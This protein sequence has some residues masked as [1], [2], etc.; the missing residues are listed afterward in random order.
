[1][2]TMKQSVFAINGARFDSTKCDRSDGIIGALNV[3]AV[4]EK[5]QINQ[6]TFYRPIELW[7]TD[8]SMLWVHCMPGN[9]ANM[10]RTSSWTV[11]P[12]DKSIQS[13]SQK[14]TSEIK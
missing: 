3:V 8:E 1:M 6:S 4:I 7:N 5:M 12:T 13:P 11:R 2:H 10:G 14:Q 9:M